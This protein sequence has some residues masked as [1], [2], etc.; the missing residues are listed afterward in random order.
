MSRRT[1][2]SGDRRQEMKNTSEGLKLFQ[3]NAK[4]VLK[5]K[6]HK[7]SIGERI[8]QGEKK[9]WEADRRTERWQMGMFRSGTNVP[10]KN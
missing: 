10:Q 3:K 7:L 9:G 6:I 1:G 4:S 2:G 8:N 5:G